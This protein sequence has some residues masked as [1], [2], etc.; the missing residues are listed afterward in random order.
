MNSAC[1]ITSAYLLTCTTS[2]SFFAGKSKKLFDRRNTASRPSSRDTAQPAAAAGG[3]PDKRPPEV[4][5]EG[6]SIRP[7]DAS[8]IKFDDDEQKQ[9]SSDSDDDEGECASGPLTIV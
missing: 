6:Y 1:A 3:S 8:E 4:D 9:W 7:A 2:N 5:E